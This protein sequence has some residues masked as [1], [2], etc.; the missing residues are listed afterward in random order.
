M[1]TTIDKCHSLPA[2]HSFCNIH[3]FCR[4]VELHNIWRLHSVNG[5]IFPHYPTLLWKSNSYLPGFY[6]RFSQIGIS[7]SSFIQNKS[8]RNLS[9]HEIQE[10]LN[11][12]STQTKIMSLRRHLF[13]DNNSVPRPS[14]N[15]PHL[16]SIV[17]IDESCYD[18][19][20]S[21][22]H[23]NSFRIPEIHTWTL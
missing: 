5:Y 6:F 1:V 18:D 12:R 8:L 3:S 17:K 10:P 7:I 20:D 11:I 14:T 15:N 13:T 16:S 19:E 9:R 23:W 2:V 21:R 22:Q 4:S